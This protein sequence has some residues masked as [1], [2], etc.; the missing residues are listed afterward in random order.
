MYAIRHCG[1][2]AARQLAVRTMM[3]RPLSHLAALQSHT[4]SDRNWTVMCAQ[5]IMDRHQRRG[6]KNFGHKPERMPLFTKC[7]YIFVG[8]SMILCF[9]DWKR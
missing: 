6:Y 9:V 4:A 8:T 7:W 3:Q 2:L 5:R 1:V